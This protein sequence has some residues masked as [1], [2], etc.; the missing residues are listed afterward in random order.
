LAN[1]IRE[2]QFESKEQEKVYINKFIHERVHPAG[3]AATKPVINT[4]VPLHELPAVVD[5]PP[6]KVVV[7]VDPELR[8]TVESGGVNCRRPQVVVFIVICCWVIEIEP[9][10]AALLIT[11]LNQIA[12]PAGELTNNCVPFTQTLVLQIIGQVTGTAAR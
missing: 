12:D 2:K 6:P 4:P 9:V 11:A 1:K 10:D 8:V 7:E 5:Q 3:T